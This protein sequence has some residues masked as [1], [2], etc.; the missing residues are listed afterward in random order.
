MVGQRN[1]ANNQLIRRIIVPKSI[2]GA[3]KLA[4]LSS[5][6]QRRLIERVEAEYPESAID[7]NGEALRLQSTEKNSKC[8]LVFSFNKKKRWELLDELKRDAGAVSQYAGCSSASGLANSQRKKSRK[9]KRNSIRAAQKLESEAVLNVGKTSEGGSKNSTK[10]QIVYEFVTPLTPQRRNSCEASK[11]KSKPSSSSCSSGNGSRRRRRAQQAPRANPNA[12]DDEEEDNLAD[13]VTSRYVSSNTDWGVQVWDFVEVELARA[14][15]RKRAS[16]EAAGWIVD[17]VDR[18]S[19]DEDGSE[20]DWIVLDI[21][22]ENGQTIEQEL[23]KKVTNADGEHSDEEKENC[24]DEVAEELR[25]DA[26]EEMKF[27]EEEIDEEDFI[28][29]GIRK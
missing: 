15:D 18:T 27:D 5:D 22:D 23:I 2:L 20:V 6:E 8:Q 28:L 25:Q 14:E 7:S 1:A 9:G 4:D 19:D 12:L 11:P 17:D 26:S 29:V 16:V 10:A 3:R 13:S 24:E 21:V